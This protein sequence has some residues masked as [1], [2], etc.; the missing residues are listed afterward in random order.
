MSRSYYSILTASGFSNVVAI[1]N[2]LSG[3]GANPEVAAARVALLDARFAAA[4]VNGHVRVTEGRGH[5]HEIATAAVAQRRRHRDCV[6]RRRNDQ[7]GRPRARGHRHGPGHR[8]SRIRQWLRSEP[9]D[10][11]GARGRARRDP[12]RD[13]SSRRRRSGERPI[14]LQHRRLRFR[15]GDCHA[16]QR[17]RAGATGTVALHPDRLEPGVQLSGEPVPADAGRRAV[18]FARAD[19]GVRQWRESTATA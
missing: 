3:A 18:R 4:A 2:P 19:G 14:V 12:A 7:R 9:G 15:R 13:G 8:S 16:L 1:V 11:D 6:G 5:A 10:P 17:L